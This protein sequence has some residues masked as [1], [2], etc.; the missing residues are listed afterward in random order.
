MLTN[1]TGTIQREQITGNSGQDNNGRRTDYLISY[2]QNES[3]QDQPQKC[4]VDTEINFYFDILA[5]D[6][7]EGVDD[8]GQYVIKDGE[9]NGSMTDSQNDDE[10]S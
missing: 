6:F 8:D 3:R 7:C 1:A 2:G 4:D 5:D 9:R 10:Q